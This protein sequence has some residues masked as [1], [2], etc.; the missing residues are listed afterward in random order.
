MLNVTIA[1]RIGR[2]AEVRMAQSGTTVASWTVAVNKGYGDKEKTVWVRCAL[3][4]K[5]ADALSPHL[6]KGTPVCVTG[7]GD[8]NE[9]TDREG[10][11][12]TSLEL[13]VDN[14]TFMGK[15]VGEADAAPVQR[16]SG[17]A[18]PKAIE[19]DSIEDDLPF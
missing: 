8:L 4:G 6:L 18:K 19:K 9:W 10:K 17:P 11:E 13:L 14:L 3:F 5:R 12:R 16:E 1:G 7:Q 15:S 2:D